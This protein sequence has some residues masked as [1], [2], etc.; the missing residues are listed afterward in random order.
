MC[1]REV[2]ILKEAI[3]STKREFASR[4]EDDTELTVDTSVPYRLQILTQRINTAMGKLDRPDNTLPYLRL[5][6][7][8]DN[9]RKYRRYGFMFGGLSAARDNMR[10]ILPRILRILV[11]GKPITIL[12]MSAVPFEITNVV[13]SLVC[14]LVF[15]FALWS[16]R[17]QQI[18]M[19]LV[20]EEAH[21][22][23]PSLEGTGFETMR[24]AIS[25]IAQEGANMAFRSAW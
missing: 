16:Q 4:P 21:R 12:D 2:A 22:Y 3:V 13:V 14:R 20:C 15:D 9:L 25:L 23:I 19:L 10:E 17:E 24:R 11:A 18:Q 6:T 7:T 8:I 5:T 1:S